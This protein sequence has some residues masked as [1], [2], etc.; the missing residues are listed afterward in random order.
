MFLRS[1]FVL[2]AASGERL[3]TAVSLLEKGRLGFDKRVATTHY[4]LRRAAELYSTGA[5]AWQGKS[6]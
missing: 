4:R 5:Q 1:G 2:I 6:V 3:H